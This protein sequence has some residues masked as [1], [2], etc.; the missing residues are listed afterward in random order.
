[1]LRVKWIDLEREP[2]AKPNPKYPNGVDVDVSL[3]KKSCMT[4]VP[5]P[6]PR[7]GY[8]RVICDKCDASVAVTTAGRPD[9]PRSVRIPCKNVVMQ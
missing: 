8:L 5:Y 1:M 2:K 4:E 9:D 7:C 6:S 3:G